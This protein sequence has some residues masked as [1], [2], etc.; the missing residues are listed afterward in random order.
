MLK[1][2]LKW[3]GGKSDELE[4]IH[5]N[6]PNNIRDYIEPFLGGGACL[7]S[8]TQDK[9]R[10]AYANDLASELID[11]YNMIKEKNERFFRYTLDIW[12]YWESMEYCS[13]ELYE[14]IR[15]IYKEYKEN[16]SPDKDKVLKQQV[17]QL[18]ED[19]LQLLLR[20]LPDSLKVDEK[21]LVSEFNKS[22]LSK[23]KNI[24]RKE[25]KDGDLPE[26]DYKENFE[27]G[28]R[29]SLYTYYRYLYNQKK[30]YI[31]QRELCIALFFY[32]R[33]FCY[34]SMFRYNS[35]GEFNVPY[36]GLSY[37]RKNFLLKIEYI[38]SDIVQAS[39]AEMEFRN[40]DFEIFVNQLI[41]EYDDFMFLDPPYDSDFSTYANN[42]FDRDDQVRLANYLINECPCRFMLI[43]KNT[44][45]IAELYEGEENIYIRG[46]DKDYKVSFMD[47]NDKKVKHLM[48]TNYL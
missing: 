28:I 25:K 40:Q 4:I 15:V 46:F 33:E 12:N 24:N 31:L 18:V 16:I 11:F 45:F 39:L 22:I 35:K 17:N 13:E 30:K 34:S 2:F 8:L 32:L 38:Q 47:R 14:T 42:T 43:I 21:R 5:K 36:G 26:E 6:M 9:Y 29:A 44:D 10:M 27:A 7:L 1:P 23:L 37:N 20:K 48:I 19:N 3:P 41:L